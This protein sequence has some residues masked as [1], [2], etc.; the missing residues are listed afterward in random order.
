MKSNSISASSEIFEHDV[1]RWI[2][3]NANNLEDCRAKFCSINALR[4][5]RWAHELFEPSAI[6]A[7]FC[8]LNAT[9][10]AVA[11]FIS[12]AKTHGHK[13]Y[14]KEVNLHDHQS[15]ALISVFAQ[16]CSGVAKQ[17]RLAIAVAPNKD[18]L[19]FRLPTGNGYDYRYG[20][21]HLSSFRIYPNTESPGKDDIALGDMPTLEELQAEV[22]RVAE[23]RNALLYAT[24]TGIQTGFKDPQASLLRETQLSLGLI[25]AAVDM[26]TNP[27]QDRP[28]INKV[29]EGMASLNTK[30]K[31]QEC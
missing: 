28:F 11:A 30:G 21:L 20:N 18:A 7:S 19:A 26:Y 14:A 24:N 10:E 5:L 17:G 2:I 3:D 31:V 22:K 9:E 8:A 16:R 15:K 13:Q 4:F 23:A 12:A 1:A 6:V 25:W 27:D 29:L